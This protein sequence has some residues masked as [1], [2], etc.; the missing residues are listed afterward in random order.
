MSTLRTFDLAGLSIPQRH[1]LLLGAVGPRPI[2]FASTIDALGRP[3]LS[4]FSFFNCFGS[5]P[6]IVVFS[7][8]RRGRD[9]TTKHTLHNVRAVPEVVINVVDF[10]MTQQANVAS[11]EYG[12]GVNEFVKAGFTPIASERVRP[13]RVKESPAQ[14]ECS[15]KQ[16]VETG[17][18]GAAGNLVICEV[19]VMHVREDLLTPEGVID[20]RR[21]DL[22][23]RM[24][25]HYYCRANG[26]ALFELAQPTKHTGIGVDA[27]PKDI[28]ESHVLTGND[29]GR[30]ANLPALPDE[31]SVNEY[32]LTE[33]ADLFIAM[34]G[35]KAALRKALHQRAQQLLAQDRTD[36]AVRTL[37]AFNER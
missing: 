6:P 26:D 32:K 3:N 37:L 8:A 29:L 2:A 5:N 11:G 9:N 10:G 33:L 16:V 4:P 17:D 35:D 15:V 7:P 30:I 23:G 24:G 13:F 22:V 31:T 25:G 19:L 21:I 1:G 36:E 27:L 18:Q 34:D 14:L 12:E 20:Q 28:R